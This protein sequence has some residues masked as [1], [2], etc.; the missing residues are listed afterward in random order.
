M[1]LGLHLV[2]MPWSPADTPSI[3]L[4]AL[5]AH[6]DRAEKGAVRT[7]TYSPF[8]SLLDVVAR[9]HGTDAFR[10]FEELAG[11]GEHVFFMLHAR[12]FGVGGKPLSPARF[13]TL[14]ERLHAAKLAPKAFSARLLDQIDRATVAFVEQELLPA[15]KAGERAV[16]GFTMN[17]DQVFSSMYCAKLLLDRMPEPP[18]LVFGGASA[19]LPEV[20]RLARTLGVDG[21]FLLGEGER[22]LELFLRALRLGTDPRR[23][24]PGILRSTTDEP[25]LELPEEAFQT[26]FASL[27]ELALPDF[28][29]FFD[30]LRALGPRGRRY[31][32]NLALPIEGSR[33]C[34]AH[35]DFCGLNWQW[36][37]FRK[38]PAERVHATARNLIERHGVE[39]LRFVDNVCDTWAEAYADRM[40]A[41]GA[42]SRAFMEL[43]AHHPEEFWTKLAVSGV[44]RVQLGLEAISPPLLHRMAKGTKVVQNILAHKALTE[45]GIRSCSNLISHHPRSTEADVEETIR[46]IELIPHLQPFG[47]SRFALSVGSPLYS[48]IGSTK[49]ARLKPQLSAPLPPA[50]A[51]HMIG[52][53]FEMPPE[54]DLSARAKRAWDFFKGWYA[55]RQKRG[56]HGSL[57][58]K[59][60]SRGRAKVTDTRFGRARSHVLEP[61]EARVLEICARGL[62]L[63]A[64][65]T[66]AGQGTK[67]VTE[68]LERLVA[69]RLVLKTEHYYLSLAMRSRAELISRLGGAAE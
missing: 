60:D 65:A 21:Y 4:G 1:K 3:Q 30:E 61:D 5:K 2:A 11:Y 54:D 48:S 53:G 23:A 67:R 58:V 63:D 32:K 50:L 16:I 55:S 9:E 42:T 36:K 68:T 64:V 24:T 69:E 41:D 29:E 15:V 38:S 12:R 46:V 49:K 17:F 8:F 27:E 22:K 13:G 33:G 28:A 20:F 43:R 45:L 35:C 66:A 6:I 25:L 18:I 14:R 39:H 59:T 57:R 40:I 56:I 47:L 52:F 37:G 19:A 51:K 26:Q 34:F 10:L 62:P 31:L 7:R 44:D